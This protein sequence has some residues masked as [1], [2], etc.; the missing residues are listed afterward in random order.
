MT[1]VLSGISQNSR[2]GS[3]LLVV[4]TSPANNT[5][6]FF[7]EAEFATVIASANATVSGTQVYF[8]TNTTA[9]SAIVVAGSVDNSSRLVQFQSF[10]DLGKNYMIY[11]PTDTAGSIQVLL[12]VFTKVRR[13]GAVAAAVD[14]EGDNGVVGYICTWSAQQT[15]NAVV[16]GSISTEAPICIVARTGFGHAF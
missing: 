10:K 12:A 1:S 2:S 16:S 7:T 5:A 14:W 3:L 6:R 11:A 13:I 4:G 15:N 8:T 9:N